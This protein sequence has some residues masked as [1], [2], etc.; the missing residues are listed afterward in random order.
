MFNAAAKHNMQWHKPAAVLL[1]MLFGLMSSYALGI[2]DNEVMVNNVWVDVPLTQVF[3]DISTETE[4]IIA[5]CPHVTDQLISLDAGSGRPLEECL[6]ELVIGRGFFIY[7]KNKKFYLIGCGDPACPS[8]AEVANSNRIYLKYITAKHLKSSL[9]KSTQEYISSGERPNEVLLYATPE[10]S[11]RIM[12]IIAKL[13]VPQP[14]VVLEV[15]VVELLEETSDEFGFDWEYSGRHFSA[16]NEGSIGSFTSMAKYTSVPAS[17]LTSLLLTL[18]S[19]VGQQKASIR[20]RPRVATINGEKAT[21]DIS[22]DEYFS[23]VKDVSGAYLRTELQI[24]KTGVLLQITPQIGDKGDITVDVMTEVSDVVARQ[25]LV[26][27]N[28][29]GDLPIVR[30]RKADTCVRV[31]Q[32]DAIVIGG[33]IESQERSDDKKVPGLSGVPLIGGL[34]TS[35]NTTTEKKEVVIF[36]TPRLMKDAK[37][38]F[39][40]RNEM[41]SIEEELKSLREVVDMLG[42]SSQADANS[43][44]VQDIA[45]SSEHHDLPNVNDELHALKDTV[46]LLD[47][48]N[49]PGQNLPDVKENE[50]A[51]KD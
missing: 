34:F 30:R 36:I 39:I 12:E 21:I 35:K 40:S 14:Q 32:G 49:K 1:S 24:V 47:A 50:S 26:A 42:G 6:G 13:D 28:T 37:D 51:I 25:N 23:I 8:F 33:L 7:P 27:G 2:D 3:R 43:S 16:S 31:K 29:S 38:P 15:L 22:L 19:L 20:S 44:D 9:P 48:K 41:I 18:K 11:K 4:A 10:I 5:T 17:E 46:V 45:V